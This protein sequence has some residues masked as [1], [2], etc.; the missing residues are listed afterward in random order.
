MDV[1]E[2]IKLVVSDGP[3][4]T[5]APTQK[6]TEKPTDP[7]E[8]EVTLIFTF[9][10]PT[11]RTEN[12]VL[13]QRDQNGNEIEGYEDI[14]VQAGTPSIQV[15]LTGSGT[16]FYQLYIDGAYYKTEKVEFIVNG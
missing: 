5:E 6:P 11:D 14:P 16:E 10:L 12:Y 8:Q 7:P 9:N 15:E 3:A 4:P 1:N 13:S 2:E